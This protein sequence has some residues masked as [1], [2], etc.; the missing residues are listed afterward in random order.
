MG[1]EFETSALGPL[2]FNTRSGFAPFL[3]EG[4]YL[5]GWIASVS[6]PLWGRLNFGFELNESYDSD[7][8]EGTKKNDVRF[9]S[10]LGW[11]F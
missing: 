10:T 3:S 11:T 8:P 5:V 7:P 1:V 4:R 6:L 2:T 9:L